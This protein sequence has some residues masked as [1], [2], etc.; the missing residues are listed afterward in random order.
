[1]SSKIPRKNSRELVDHR[2]LQLLFK[3]LGG[4]SKL[5]VIIS[6]LNS[7]WIVLELSKNVTDYGN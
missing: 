7:L 6:N 1:V 4:I 5:L 3:K 2:W